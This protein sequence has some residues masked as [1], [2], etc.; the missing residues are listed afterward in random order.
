VPLSSNAG[1]PVNNSDQLTL[2]D[3]FGSIDTYSFM[4]MVAPHYGVAGV[5]NTKFANFK[6]EQKSKNIRHPL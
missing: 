4:P 1:L 5:Q 3:Q 2:E 6:Y